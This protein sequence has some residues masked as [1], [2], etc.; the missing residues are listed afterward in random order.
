MEHKENLRGFRFYVGV[1]KVESHEVR[2]RKLNELVDVPYNFHNLGGSLL[3][4]IGVHG[5]IVHAQQSHS[6]MTGSL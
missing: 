4:V 1:L 3:N 5:P 2:G 6:H